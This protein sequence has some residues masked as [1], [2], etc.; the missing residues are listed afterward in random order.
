MPNPEKSTVEVVSKR[1]PRTSPLPG[2]TE[3]EHSAPLTIEEV[4]DLVKLK[5]VSPTENDNL[6]SNIVGL[7][8]NKD[9][10]S[11]I[12]SLIKENADFRFYPNMLFLGPSGT[13]KTTSAFAI[14]KELDVPIIVI[15]TQKLVSVIPDHK[16][17]N[18]VFEGI[19]SLLEKTGDCVVLFKEI[20]YVNTFEH[21]MNVTLC[22][23]ICELL[24]NFKNNLFIASS[25]QERN[26][27]HA[28]FIGQ[29][30]FDTPV[31]FEC[32]NHQ[33]RIELIKRAIADY[34]YEDDIDYDKLS[35]DFID[36]SGGDIRKTLKSAYIQCL[37]NGENKLNYR[38]IN[39]AI[40]IEQYGKEIKKMTDKEIRLTAYHEAGHVILGYYGCPEYKV[41]KVEVKHR[42]G[43]LGLTIGESDEEKDTYTKEDMIGRIILA[44]GGKVAEQLMIGTTSTGVTG[45]LATATVI[46]EAI[47]KKFGMDDDFGPV[48]LDD[49]VFYSDV[50][51]DDADIK[52][53]NLL[54]STY[55][56]AVQIMLEHK[57]K[58]IAVAEALI[59]N[60][61]LYKE[62]VLEILEAP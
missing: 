57:D 58:L 55:A 31:T 26:E 43:T 16:V 39:S 23:K 46:A 59:K 47:I 19:N 44:F 8:D 17:M 13:G 49:E 27:F 10:F 62:E 61:V 42:Q 41:S 18:R 36:Y 29:D 30:G 40:S 50:L 24:S 51:A 22:T 11:Q 12:I 38:R 53:Q 6:L 25:S 28:F 33:E 34:P 20:Q 5:V 7:K 15:D 48:F 35:R 32:P 56:K 14:A 3:K 21:N 60:E 37:I 52:I 9:Y 54:K 4:I 2:K 45:D 1:R